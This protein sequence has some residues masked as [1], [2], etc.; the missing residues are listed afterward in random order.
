MAAPTLASSALVTVEV[1]KRHLG[2]EDNA[3]DELLIQVINQ[4]SDAIERYCGRAFAQADYVEFQAINDGGVI[5][6]RHY[7]LIAVTRVAHGSDR[8]IDVTYS[9]TGIRAMV[10]VS[11]TG[12]T[13]TST[14]TAGT[15]TTTSLTFA[16]NPTFSTMATAIG[17]VSGWSATAIEG[18]GLSKS[19]R[20]LSMS[21]KNQTVT[22]E[23]PPHDLDRFEVDHSAG[24]IKLGARNHGYPNWG[25]VESGRDVA[26]EY[27]AGY[28]AIPE[29]LQGVALDWIT[30]AISETGAEGGGPAGAVTSES[31]PGY[32]YTI[33]SS[34]TKSAF[35]TELSAS[36]KKALD[37]FM[38]HAVGM[39]A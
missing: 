28:A 29:A 10:N 22:L 3:R 12:V 13:L 38:N 18:D 7:P 11:S 36:M 1:A 37:P 8:A 2:Y 24:T 26:V 34:T 14:S 9:G 23:Y 19:L 16:T 33:S 20:R 39:A 4:A 21:A 25:G 15:T 17:T 30:A 32:S 6:L 35:T 27:T 5:V 31:T